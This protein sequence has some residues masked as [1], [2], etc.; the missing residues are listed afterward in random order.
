MGLGTP[1]IGLGTHNGIG[2][3]EWDQE[4]NSGIGIPNSGIR[5]PMMGSGTQ[6]GVG[7]P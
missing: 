3:P 4:P 6:N 2:N 7:N 1:V 5:N